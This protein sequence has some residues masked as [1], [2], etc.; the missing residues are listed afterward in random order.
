MYSCACF[1]G[2]YTAAVPNP[3]MPHISGSTTVWANAQATAA[4]A[5]LPPARRISMPASAASG[6]GHTTM[7]CFIATSGSGF[8]IARRRNA[9]GSVGPQVQVADGV[10]PLDGVVHRQLHQLADR[11]GHWRDLHRAE[12]VDDD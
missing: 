4:S 1:D 8:S 9:C 11:A 12:L 7:P 2:I 3:A 6:C 5:A 10:L